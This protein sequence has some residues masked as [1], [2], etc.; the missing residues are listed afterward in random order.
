MAK[1]QMDDIKFKMVRLSNLLSTY[2]TFGDLVK[3]D[4]IQQTNDIDNLIAQLQ[5]VQDK[6]NEKMRKGEIR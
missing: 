1:N 4:K 6:V 3:A 5:V 2:F